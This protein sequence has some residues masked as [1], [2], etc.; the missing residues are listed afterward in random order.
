MKFG[1]IFM[2]SARN[3]AGFMKTLLMLPKFFRLI[4]RLLFDRRVP[5]FPKLLFAS[6]MIYALSPLDF[7]PE[8]LFPL[9]GFTD[10]VLLIILSAKHLF[11]SCPAVVLQEHVA[12]L[13]KKQTAER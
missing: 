10:D 9:L 2:Q 4:F 13:E 12:E 6:T 11:K 1:S 8:F 3:P 5:F 7:L